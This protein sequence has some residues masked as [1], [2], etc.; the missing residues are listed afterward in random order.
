MD[1]HY[2]AQHY[3]QAQVDQDLDTLSELMHDDIVVTYPQSGETIRGSANYAEML[4]NY[5][6][7]LADMEIEQQHAP[8]RSVQ[9]RT[10]PM[11]MPVITVSGE[12][13]LF[14]TESVA[15]YPDGSVYHVAGILEIHGGQVTKETM[16]FAAPFDAPDWREQYRES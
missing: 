12:G 6:D 16:Y 15:T 3:G 14:F 2:V 5:S 1:N 13:N 11:G 7:G 8:E 10:S 9:V 4:R